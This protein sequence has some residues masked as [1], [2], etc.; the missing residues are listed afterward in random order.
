MTYGYSAIDTDDGWFCEVWE[1]ETGQTVARTGF[2]PSRA[3]ACRAAEDIIAD[4]TVG[5]EGGPNDDR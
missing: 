2:Y 4:N 1:D 3:E 5:V